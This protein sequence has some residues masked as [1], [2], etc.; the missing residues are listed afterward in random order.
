MAHLRPCGTQAVWW[1]V[2]GATAVLLVACGGS[3]GGGSADPAHPNGRQLASVVQYEFPS[4]LGLAGFGPFVEKTVIGDLD[5]DGRN[6]VATF[7]NSFG[8][9]VIVMYQAQDGTFDSFIAI[10]I[11]DLGLTTISDIAL[12]DLNGD[13][14]LDLAVV[15]DPP[16]QT[17]GNGPHLRVLYQDPTGEFGPPV[18][19]HVTD[20]SFAQGLKLV[21][22]DVNSDGLVDVVVGSSPA[23]VLLQEP[24]GSLGT[25]VTVNALFPRGEIHVADMNS[26]GMNDLIYQAGG[27]SIGILLQLAPG[28]FSDTPQIYPMVTSYW[29]SFDTFKVGDVNG[30]GKADVVVADPGNDGYLNIFLQN[31]GGTLDSPQLITVAF[32]TVS[33]IEI[34]DVDKDG[35][36][37]LICEDATQVLIL[38]QKPDHSFKDPVAYSLP[39]QTIGSPSSPQAMSVGD[40]DA[41]GWSDVVVAFE[42]SIFV[43]HNGPQ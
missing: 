16:P 18:S 4:S 32:N 8:S 29:P 21:I 10:P 5:G 30:D 7:S 27:K 2:I 19:F 3:G 11:T 43:L 38:Y 25:P 42:N 40:V 41:D 37:D 22:G 6:D 1:K 28:V 24:G 9:Y 36:N 39:T 20:E 26:D 34:G 23:R 13:G 33:G 17:I 15:G 12:G 35:L 14:R 31:A